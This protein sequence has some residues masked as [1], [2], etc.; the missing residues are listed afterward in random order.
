MGCLLIPV[1]LVALALANVV[2]VRSLRRRQAGAGWWVALAIA[3]LAGAA[4]G[5]WGGFFFEY[6]PSPRLRVFGAPVPAAFFHWEGPPGEEQWVDFI[7]PA[8]LLFA[9][10]N[11]PIMALLCGCPVGAMFWVWN[12]RAGRVVG[13]PNPIYGSPCQEGVEEAERPVRSRDEG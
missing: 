1:A 11:V 2:T 9:G 6:Q 13:P 3:W 12:W 10:S 4:V 8:P 7:T 5:L